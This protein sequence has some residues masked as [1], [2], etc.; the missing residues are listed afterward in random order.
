MNGK[1]AKRVGNLSSWISIT[2]IITASRATE[3]L[4]DLEGLYAYL[5]GGLSIWLDSN[6]IIERIDVHAKLTPDRR[7]DQSGRGGLGYRMH[8]SSCSCA[9]E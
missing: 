9:V 6:Y 3:T 1:I 8:I 4:E 5:A 7:N 2:I